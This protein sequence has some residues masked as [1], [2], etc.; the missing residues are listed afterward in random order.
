MLD[1]VIDIHEDAQGDVSIL[2]FKGKLDAVTSCTAE[3]KV[4]DYINKG[5][6][7]LIFDLSE[8]SYMTSAGMRM[9]LSVG[10]K[11]K[12]LKGKLVL[13]GVNSVILGLLSMSGLEQIL[14]LAK[15][16]EDAL[17]SIDDQ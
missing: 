16:N 14:E 17:K 15:T 13:S 11:L 12:T 10:K 9:L 1:G 4:F 5:R 7:K 2:Y 8:V 6:Y 3:R